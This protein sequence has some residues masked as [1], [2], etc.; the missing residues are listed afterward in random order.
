MLT[1]RYYQ[2]EAVDAVYRH[3]R[4]QDSNPCVVVPTGGGKT[5]ILATICRD[6]VLTWNGR[7]LILSHVKELLKQS[8][9][10]L[11][12][13]APELWGKVGVYSAG[14]KSRD[15]N[16]A[17]IVGGIQSVY[18]RA[19]QLGRFDLILVDEAHL[20]PPAGEGR[21]RKFI[22]DARVINP[23]VRII[24]FTATPYRTESGLICDPA[25]ILNAV[26]YEVGV[27]E[28][29]VRGYLSPLIS[30]AGKEKADMSGLHV[31]A[32][33]FIPGE[34][35][36]LMNTDLLV[37]AACRE[38][39]DYTVD[40]NACL[41]FSSGVEH[42]KHIAEVLQGK[43]AAAQTIFGDTPSAER[44]RVIKDFKAGRVKYLVNMGVLTT[45]FDAPNIDCVAL[46]RPTL[47]PG[48]YSQMVGRGF[49]KCEG[50][51]NAL[52]LDFGGNILRHGPVDD[53]RVQGSRKGTAE[54]GEAPVKECPEC[55]ALIAPGFA[56]CP[57]CGFAFPAREVKH[58]A[59]ASL[60][61]ILTGEV[62]TAEQR[63]DRIYYKAHFKRDAPEAPPTMRVEY[64]LGN[65]GSVSEWL[66]FEHTGW[67]QQKAQSWWRLR[68]S[69]PV[70]AT[71]AEAV[72]L[73]QGGALAEA[74]SI[75]VKKV[76][77]EKYDRIIGY[78]LG[79]KP[80]WREREPGEDADAAWAQSVGIDLFGSEGGDDDCPF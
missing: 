75:T 53:V 49:R 80:L 58:E 72:E 29:I 17:I 28:L 5:P 2:Q 7:V 32:G 56:T 35:E 33:E 46:L 73:A 48:L 67:A 37:D 70:P 1:L 9:D 57:H 15:T 13:V 26:C 51:K 62:T 18:K 20:I 36:S 64:M 6:S 34:V 68:S 21:Y 55:R 16:Q 10:H 39:L 25:N 23:E 43:G 38:I 4:E 65:L 12:R 44:D 8:A 14:L 54:P 45:G 71:V 41:I 22:K 40:R 19:C 63:V 42:G 52:I 60:A 66:C 79:E 74:R 47:S 27:K 50:K 78:E 3:L 61:G 69:A 24:G 11:A 31:Q 76:V 30:K 77:G 59:R